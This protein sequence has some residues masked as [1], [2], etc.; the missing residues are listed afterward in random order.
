[1]AQ[2][3]MALHV[4]PASHIRAPVHTAVSSTASCSVPGRALKMPQILGPCHL[5]AGQDGILAPGLNVALPQ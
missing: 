5:C 2:K 1:M 4:T 3:V